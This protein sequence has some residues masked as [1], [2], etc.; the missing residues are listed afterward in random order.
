MSARAVRSM[1]IASSHPQSADRLRTGRIYA[2][3]APS[4]SLLSVIDEAIAALRAESTDLAGRQPHYSALAITTAADAA[5]C[6]FRLAPAQ[7]EGLNRSIIRLLGLDRAS[8]DHFHLADGE[9]LAVTRRVQ[10]RTRPNLLV[11]S[12]WVEMSSRR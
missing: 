7:T 8:P 6:V 4:C 12:H 1:P 11:D 5:R 3:L 2:G 10:R 9:T